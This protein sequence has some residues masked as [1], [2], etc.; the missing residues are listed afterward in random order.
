MAMIALGGE[1]LFDRL[2]VVSNGWIDGDVVRR[3]YR[4]MDDAFS[5]GDLSHLEN[6]LRT[7]ECLCDRTLVQRGVSR[8]RRAFQARERTTSSSFVALVGRAIC[9]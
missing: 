4:S 3:L 8:H 1:R 7:M 2:N 5:R 9:L 6:F